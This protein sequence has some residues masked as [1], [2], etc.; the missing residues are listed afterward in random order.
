MVFYIIHPDQYV[1][2]QLGIQECEHIK[3]IRADLADVNTEALKRGKFAVVA[4]G[5]SFGLMDGGYD[6]AIIRKFGQEVQDEIQSRIAAEWYGEL[7]IGCA[8]S[9]G[10]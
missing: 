6:L 5:N 7:P 4:P 10:D 9:C 3:F 8:T 2:E 1:F